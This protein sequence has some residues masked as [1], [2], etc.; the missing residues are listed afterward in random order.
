MRDINET[1]VLVTGTTSG[2]GRGVALALASEG[3]RILLHGRDRA[4]L[5]TLANE[6]RGSA[7]EA[8]VSTYVADLASL[9]EVRRLASDVAR[10]N[11]R[12][13]LLINNAGVGF[14]PPGAPRELSKDGY[15]LRLAVNYLAPYVLTNLLLPLLRSSAPARIANVSSLGQEAIDFDDIMLEREYSGRRAYRQSKTA[16]AMFTF[17]LAERLP[18]DK[19]TVNCLHPATYMDTGMVRVS[20]IAPM[21][22]VA[23]GVDALLFV[24]TSPRLDGV[25]GEFFDQKREARAISQ[26]YDPSARDRLRRITEELTSVRM[27]SKIMA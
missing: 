11:E 17:D 12:L 26:A 4:K 20:R 1:T 22:T 2:L 16:L 27:P 6:I 7:R 8:D 19:I 18:A 13:D 24:A 14:G 3:A 10:D 25:T 5:E 21:S 9:R 15:E 23:E